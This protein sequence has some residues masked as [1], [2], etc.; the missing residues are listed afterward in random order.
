MKTKKLGNSD[1][2]VSSQGLGC[3]GMSEFY[4]DSDKENAKQV[5]STAVDLGVNFFDTADMYGYGENEKLVGEA[6]DK[7]PNRE[8]LVIATKCGIVRDKSQPGLR[9]FNNSPEY[10]ISSCSSSTERL[11]TYIDLYYLHRV[12]DD[13]QTLNHAMKAM[14]TLLG[15][16]KIR[17][18]GL[19][20]V[21]AENIKFAHAC[22]LDLT[23]GKH[24]LS[25]IQTEYS[26]LSR[27][28]E[29]N[30]ALDTCHELGLSFVAYSPICRGLL[31]GEINSLDGLHSND[32]RRNLPRFSGNNLD[33]NNQ[34]TQSMSAIANDKHCTTAQLSLAWLTHQH[35]NVITLPGTK[36][37]QYLQQN[38]AAV[39]ITL[40]NDEYSH[41]TS[42]SDKFIV[43]GDRY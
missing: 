38:V 32:F 8:K 6:I 26:L 10:I 11:G 36:K 28:V 39:D 34:F 30:G 17:A 19:S 27:D 25:A 33:Y 35:D 15:Q 42:L 2:I 24:G 22:L 37:L 12:V 14:A 1:I 9:E 40:T 31:S 29:Q 23:D 43:K 16:G 21:S 4:G 41:I 5:I 13:K 20:E 3:M 7:L 18:V